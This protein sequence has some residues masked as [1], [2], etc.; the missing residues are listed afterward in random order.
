MSVVIQMLL[1]FICW[2]CCSCLKDSFPPATS[3]GE[4]TMG[5]KVDGV[6]WVASSNDF[7]KSRT[8]A[9]KYLAYMYPQSEALDITGISPNSDMYFRIQFPKEGSYQYT[10]GDI[11]EYRVF[12][13]SNGYSIDYSLDL[14]DPSNKLIITHYDKKIISATFSFKLKTPT[15][16]IVSI[17]SGRFDVTISF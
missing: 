14:N 7:K 1:V 10:T 3:S 17:T 2:C 12:I 15:G 4:G 6:K 9:Y 13:P 8:M 11:V 16:E 5:F